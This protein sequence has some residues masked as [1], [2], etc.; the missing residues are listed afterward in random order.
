M[1]R[2]LQHYSKVE[3][4]LHCFNFIGGTFK[5]FIYSNEGLIF[6]DD[7]STLS[8]WH[9]YISQWYRDSNAEIKRQKGLDK[10][11]KKE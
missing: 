11:R 5:C 6:Q 9:F 8:S 7:P 1:N 2:E 10:P 4:V 3:E